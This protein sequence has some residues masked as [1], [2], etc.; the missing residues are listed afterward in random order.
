[1]ELTKSTCGHVDLV[2]RNPADQHDDADQG[3]QVGRYMGCID[4]EPIEDRR[5]AGDGAQT[6]GSDDTECH[7][8]EGET[9]RECADEN[10]PERRLVEMQTQ[11][12][13]RDRGRAWDETAGKAEQ[14]GLPGAGGTV[15]KSMLEVM[16]QL[17]GVGLRMRITMAITSMM[18]IVMSVLVMT[19]IAMV[20]VV[21]MVVVTG[22]R[23]IVVTMIMSVTVSRSMRMV[24]AVRVA[25]LEEHP[26]GQQENQDSGADHEV[27]FKLIA[28]QLIAI[29]DGDEGK[30]P[31]DH[32]MGDGSRQS[33]QKGLT[34]GST[35]RDDVGRDHRLRMTGLKTMQAAQDEGREEQHDGI[36]GACGD[37]VGDI[38]GRFQRSPAL[39]TKRVLSCAMQSGHA[40]RP[41]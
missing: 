27:G 20:M 7:Q 5:A 10:D 26:N 8:H 22:M 12:K 11:K 35:N 41:S 21:M 30:N 40:I 4:E 29:E 17:P 1:M 2:V 16:L 24:V 14:D 38:H 18:M 32:R 31:D 9:E 3:Y 28:D 34:D 6:Q 25:R 19:M 23:V 36:G 37:H 39:F 33:E 13:D 15:L